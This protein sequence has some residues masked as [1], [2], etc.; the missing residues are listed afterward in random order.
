MISSTEQESD[1][2]SEIIEELINNLKSDIQKR[3]YYKCRFLGKGDFSKCYELTCSEKKKFA[4]KFIPKNNLRK[5]S[6]KMNLINEIK[7]HISYHHHH[8]VA[9]EHYFEGKT[10]VYLLLEK[11]QNG[12]LKEFIKKKTKFNRIRSKILFSSTH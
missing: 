6:A 9:F 10:N 1:P 8:I 4:A 11:C 12:T 5:S 3:K 7:I 2:I